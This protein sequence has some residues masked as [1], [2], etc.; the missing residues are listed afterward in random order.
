[1][2]KSVNIALLAIIICT[3]AQISLAGGVEK[4]CLKSGRT[5]ANARLCK[6]IDAT[7]R[8][9]LGFSQQN[10]AARLILNPNKSQRVQTSTRKSEKKFWAAYKKFAKAAE[11][12][13]K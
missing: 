5:A 3:S 9:T 4:A 11:R 10:T 13:C 12:R 6:C 2:R 8:S 1:M 7:A